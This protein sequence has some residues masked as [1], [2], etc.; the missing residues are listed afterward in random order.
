MY[1][2]K[3]ISPSFHLTSSCRMAAEDEGGVVNSQ[4]LVHG[5]KNLRIADASVLPS[6]APAQPMA[7]VYMVAERCA[8]FV[9]DTWSQTHVA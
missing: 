9:K 1:I 4:L 3:Y 5:F 6:A 8:D 2:E 7:T